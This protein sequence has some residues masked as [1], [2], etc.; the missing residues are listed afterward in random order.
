[1]FNS[2]VDVKKDPHPRLVPGY[3]DGG[4]VVLAPSQFVTIAA[5][6]RWSGLLAQ[7]LSTGVMAIQYGRSYESFMTF[8]MCL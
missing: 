7:G 8:K 5:S 2:F 1:M 6:K 3:A 4:H